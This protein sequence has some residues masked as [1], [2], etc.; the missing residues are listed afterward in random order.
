[1]SS[2]GYLHYEISNFAQPGKKCNHNI[3]YW[4]NEEYIGIGTGA[5][6]FVNGK[7]YCNIKDVKEY[8][9]TVKSRKNLIC[10]SEQLSQKRRASEILIMSLRMTSGISKM[11]FFNKSGFDLLG[12]FGKQINGLAK[13]G[14]INFDDE[15]IKLTRRGMSVADSVMM[16]FV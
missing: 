12:L 11:E 15:R 3:V 14:L 10:F 6:S 2:K 4:K 7:R 5:F 1:L 13:A 9:S 8:I 16:E